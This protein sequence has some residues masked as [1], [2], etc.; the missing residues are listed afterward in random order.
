MYYEPELTDFLQAKQVED[1][2]KT[3]VATINQ[4]FMVCSL[5]NDQRVKSAIKNSGV[6]YIVFLQKNMCAA[7]AQWLKEISNRGN[8]FL[9]EVQ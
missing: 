6:K 9:Y 1:K 7:K 3:V 8:Y 2:R 5:Q 4:E